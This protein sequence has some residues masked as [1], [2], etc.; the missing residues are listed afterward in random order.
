MRGHEVSQEGRLHSN[1]GVRPTSGQPAAWG[2]P[3]ALTLS[4]A[5]GVTVHTLAD[6]NIGEDKEGLEFKWPRLDLSPNSGLSTVSESGPQ[7]R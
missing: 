6:S 7:P 3:P 1:K 2:S 4:S 5:T